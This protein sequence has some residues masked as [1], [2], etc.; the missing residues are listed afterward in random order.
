MASS[1][2]D[3]LKG[4]D[5]DNI[6][7]DSS[8]LIEE[9]KLKNEE[10]IICV[11]CFKIIFDPFESNPCGHLF[12]HSC[13]LEI[14]KHTCPCCNTKIN[15][16]HRNNNLRRRNLQLKLKC[17]NKNVGCTES[18]TI[19]NL[20]KHCR[21]CQNEIVKCNLGCGQNITRFQVN[22]H[23]HICTHRIICCD[24]CKKSFIFDHLGAHNLCC[25]EKKITC[26]SGCGITIRRV[27]MLKHASI[28]PSYKTRCIHYD[29][30]GVEMKRSELNEH[31]LDD[32][33]HIDLAKT[34]IHNL[35]SQYHNSHISEHKSMSPK[36]LTT[37]PTTRM[38]YKI[39]TFLDILDTSPSN[40]VGRR[41]SWEPAK[42]II[43]DNNS[44]QI[45][46]K[47][48]R[49]SEDKYDEWLSIDDRTRIAPYGTR[50]RQL[51]LS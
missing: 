25:T 27:D 14:N 11:I 29:I 39:G 18:F 49:Y 43:V 31:E 48:V 32:N 4:I 47:Y 40:I 6:N 20:L 46:I 19:K 37:P 24:D 13:V 17:Y 3:D 45:K 21:D 35:K 16:Y 42:V 1:F 15:G 38:S 26:P 51:M 8:F 12:C 50:T 7:L 28:C 22:D 30:C 36:I 41:Y 33:L 5:I 2:P 23:K 10:G 9:D 44:N 34:L